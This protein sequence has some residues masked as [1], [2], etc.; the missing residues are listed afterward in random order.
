MKRYIFGFLFLAVLV[1]L[2]FSALPAGEEEDANEETRDTEEEQDE[3]A[4]QKSIIVIDSADSKDIEI[5]IFEQL[6]GKSG[7]TVLRS[8]PVSRVVYQV[9][10]N[11]TT[12]KFGDRDSA[13]QFLLDRDYD[14][15]TADSMIKE[16]RNQPDTSNFANIMV[17]LNG[18]KM[19]GLGSRAF[20][21]EKMPDGY[22][23]T[24]NGQEKDFK[25]L[26]DLNKFLEEM[27]IPA[28]DKDEVDEIIENAQELTGFIEVRERD[29]I[30][31]MQVL[32]DWKTH[33]GRIVELELIINELVEKMHDDMVPD[34]D[35]EDKEDE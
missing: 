2:A 34:T 10:L 30:P 18:I 24:V 23:V 8:K 26:Q 13:R 33:N 6:I 17:R 27:G 20:P 35:D 11:G 25:E 9:E 3:Q 19:S 21:Q 15:E 4:Q 16:A 29:E 1:L 5:K 12:M 14:E 22:Y 7:V 28:F 32:E 31:D